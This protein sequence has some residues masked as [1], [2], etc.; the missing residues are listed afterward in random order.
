MNKRIKRIGSAA[1][2]SA[3]I[4]LYLSFTSVREWR[5]GVI[6]GAVA[7][8][9]MLVLGRT[10][11]NLFA[12]PCARSTKGNFDWATHYFRGFAILCIVM[13][14]WLDIFGSSELS[15]L[16]FKSSTIYFLFISGYLCQYIYDRK[17]LGWFDYYQKKVVNV[18]APFLICSVATVLAVLII[19]VNRQAVI[20]AN[21]LL[22]ADLV[23]LVA[24]GHAQMPYW[25]IPFVMVLFLISPLLCRI[26][27]PGVVAAFVGTFLMAIVFPSRSYDGFVIAFPSTFYLYTYFS[28]YYVLGFVYCR[29]KSSIDTFLKNYWWVFVGVAVITILGGYIRRLQ[30]VDGALRM[31][32]VRVCT[33]AVVIPLLNKI[34]NRRIALLNLLAK[35]SFTIFFIH[36]FFL[37]DAVKLGGFFPRCVPALAANLIL[38]IGY[39]VAILVMA[40]LLK[41]AF[42]KNSRMFIGS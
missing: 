1:I 4:A 34:A 17:H 41:V 16:F 23:R 5:F 28:C 42:G 20:G 31:S 21:G 24:T 19:G 38:L 18:V 13:T 30:L 32:I 29:C 6:T 39:F 10:E 7:F 2:I 33:M 36:A 11:D 35:Y 14:H 8:V 9:L 12:S 25:Y 15:C 40:V 37:A 3:L 27:T 26:S 22:L